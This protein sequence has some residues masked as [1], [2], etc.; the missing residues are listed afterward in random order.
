M[1]TLRRIAKSRGENANKLRAAGCL[2]KEGVSHS[3]SID[4]FLNTHKD[5]EN[6]KLC[7]KLALVRGILEHE[8]GSA[9][10][11]DELKLPRQFNRDLQVKKSWL[12]DFMYLL[13]EGVVASE[14]RGDVFKNLTII[15]FN[16]DR[17][18]EQFLFDALQSTFLINAEMAKELMG[19]SIFF[20]PMEW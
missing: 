16:Y 2:I 14:N 11:V 19:R 17:C 1:D 5:N 8:K 10:Y 12:S 6:L 9:L 3:R 18:I 7:A 20:I 13:Q 15:N 4:S